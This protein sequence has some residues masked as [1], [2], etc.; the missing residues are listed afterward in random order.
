MALTL[1]QWGSRLRALGQGGL[2]AA[3]LP[4]LNG[5]ADSI[6]RRAKL[7]VTNDLLRRRSG[8]LRNSISA[9]VVRGATGRLEIKALATAPYA[10]MQE[11]GGI[12]RPRNAKM[13]RIPIPG[14]PALTSAGVDRMP[15]PLRQVAAPGFFRLQKTMGGM[16]LVHDVGVRTSKKGKITWGGTGARSE[17]WYVL[18]HSVVI[19]PRPFLRP[20]V[21]EEARTLGPA[22]TQAVVHAIRTTNVG[23]P[24]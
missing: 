23:G 11:K 16:Y 24:T 22:L 1:E 10:R 7:S 17:L 5:A 19:P 12:Q 2:E 8:L 3:I 20:A 15:G 14:G 4:V 21:E 9:S 13:L 18:K 6:Q